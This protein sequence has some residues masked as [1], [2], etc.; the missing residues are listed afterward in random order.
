[1]ELRVLGDTG[2]V[3]SRIGLGMAAL[4]RPGYITLEHGEDLAGQYGEDAM[5]QRAY[6]VLNSAWSAGV[7]Y[8]DVARSYGLGEKFLGN[9]LTSRSV[10]PPTVT[11]GSKWGYIYTAQWKVRAE[12]HE[13]K[14]HSLPVLLRQWG[15]S[16]AL[17]KGHL[18]L[19]QIHSATIES[20]VLL[21]NDV[22]KE[23]ARLRSD[24][25][26][27]GLSITGPRQ[28]DTLRKAMEITLD[29]SRLFE[30]VQATWNLLEPSVGP[31]LLEAHT[32]GIGVIVKEVLANGRL[33]DRNME[34]GFAVK[35]A[36]L[37]GEA[38]KFDSSIDVIAL[39]ACLA[40]PFADVALSGATT[41]EQLLSNLDSCR[42]RLDEESAAR[43]AE[44]TEPAEQYWAVRAKL[45]WN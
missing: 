16:V 1:M 22:L 40:Q 30:T 42:I 26:H 44:L 6:L 37:Q 33:T 2:L 17:L 34:P 20:G 25:I 7:R 27:I 18:D 8:F 31:A 35:R 29:G 19:Y 28:A 11:V 32:A 45:P 13:I 41:V 39:A 23:L 43:L 24:N 9:W 12:K 3:V 5:E 10:A 15:E 21:K 36:L 4:G 14:E 38:S